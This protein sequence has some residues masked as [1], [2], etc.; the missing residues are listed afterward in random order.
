[1]TNLRP[2]CA[3]LVL[4]DTDIPSSCI[5]IESRD[6]LGK[7]NSNFLTD[8]FHRTLLKKKSPKARHQVNKLTTDNV[9]CMIQ[10]Y[11]K[12][13]NLSGKFFRLIKYKLYR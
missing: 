8:W 1:M 7:T 3:I 13:K 2:S 4:L 10:E 6:S 9:Y 5:P 12:L 11:T